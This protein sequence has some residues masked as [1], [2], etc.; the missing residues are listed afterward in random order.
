MENENNE[1]IL[2]AEQVINVTG[3]N[4]R[5]EGDLN[6]HPLIHSLLNRRYIMPDTSG[7]LCFNAST[8]L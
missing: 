2:R 4:L 1:E 5:L 7:G 6:I 8:Q 3:V